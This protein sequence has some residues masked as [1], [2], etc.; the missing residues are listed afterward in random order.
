MAEQ[1]AAPREPVEPVA[2]GAPG[3]DAGEQQQ[4]PPATALAAQI[5]ALADQRA[6]M[7]AEK[8]RVVKELKNKRKRLRRLKGKANQLTDQDLFDIVRMRELSMNG[9][10]VASA[11]SGSQAA[12]AGP[13]SA[14]A[15]TPPAAPEEDNHSTER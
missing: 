5:K 7:N 13:A 10:P 8:K 12:P 2:G 1:A 15:G 9:A 3:T 11:G 14:N 6:T 4:H